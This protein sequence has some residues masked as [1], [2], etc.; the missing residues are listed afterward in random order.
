MAPRPQGGAQWKAPTCLFDCLVPWTLPS[1]S[2]PPLGLCV[3][4]SIAWVASSTCWVCLQS[5]EFSVEQ[6]RRRPA[7][8]HAHKD[9]VSWRPTG[10]FPGGGGFGPCDPD[11]H[12]DSRPALGLTWTTAGSPQM[13]LLLSSGRKP[14][15]KGSRCGFLLRL[16][17]QG[18]PSQLLG[19]PWPLDVSPHLCS[20][21]DTL[22]AHVHNLPS[23]LLCTRHSPHSCP[24]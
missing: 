14:A 18:R 13:P 17:G 21:H 16:G 8:T 12:R 19:A 6:G 22:P 23:P 20:A 24:A 15:I 5:P 3:C 11:I 9:A 2:F 7:S 1:P 4:W 10:P